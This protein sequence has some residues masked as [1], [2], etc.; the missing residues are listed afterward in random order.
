MGDRR[1]NR[2]P[3]RSAWS[4]CPEEI[5]RALSDTATMGAGTPATSAA[6]FASRAGGELSQVRRRWRRMEPAR[7]SSSRILRCV[8]LTALIAVLFATAPDAMASLNNRAAQPYASSH[9]V[10][11]V[12]TDHIATLIGLRADPV[13]PHSRSGFEAVP[14]TTPTRRSDARQGGPDR[15]GQ[16]RPTPADR[17]DA[18][19]RGPPAQGF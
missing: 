16:T 12:E 6:A 9:A 13:W 5:Q 3:G 14:T 18:A 8:W 1:S 15:T 4:R 17:D 10:S 19:A 2:G 7:I 11:T